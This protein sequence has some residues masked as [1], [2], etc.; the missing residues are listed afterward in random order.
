MHDLQLRSCVADNMV[1]VPH[2]YAVEFS[3]LTELTAPHWY[4]CA[5]TCVEGWLVQWV[6]WSDVVCIPAEA[7]EPGAQ[8]QKYSF[9]YTV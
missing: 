6:C 1:A 2:W 4:R 8:A 7:I 5:N 3:I 9:Q